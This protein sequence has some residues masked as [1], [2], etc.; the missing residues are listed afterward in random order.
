MSKIQSFH[1]I[2]LII[3]K[4][5]QQKYISIEDLIKFLKT[6]TDDTKGLSK[7]NIQRDIYDINTNSL[8]STTITYCKLNKGYY[9]EEND[10]TSDLDRFIDSFNILTSLNTKNTI[11]PF[12][13]TEKYRS[14]G[15]QYI[16]P[17]V[18]AILNSC[19]I[20]LMY[21]K[22]NELPIERVLEPYAIK[23]YRGRWYIVGKVKENNELRTFALDRINKL[24]ILN[25]QFEK[26]EKID[27]NE[28][29]KYSYG[30]YSSDEY[31]IE[32]VVLSFDVNDGRYLKSLPLHDSQEII[33]DTNDEFI[34]RLRLRVTPD[35]V[36][37]LLSRSWSLKI[38]KPLSLRNEI[39]EIYRDALQ[40][41]NLIE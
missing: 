25:T 9:I 37:A 18:S 38:M 15:T 32:E 12:I 22:F 40:R 10:Y 16:Q 14:L 29:F 31:P 4:I 17:L 35:F 3:S 26:D 28:K 41:N 6:Q 24:E 27:V 39:L 2:Y 21:S 34:V 5:R 33:K 13:L 20:S 7:R 11:P 1:H 19:N 8:L 30:I 23:E 36:M